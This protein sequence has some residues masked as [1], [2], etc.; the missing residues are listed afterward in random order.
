MH[1]PR[2]IEIHGFQKPIAWTDTVLDT[3]LSYSFDI[4]EDL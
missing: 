2:G 4:G 1:G 3:V